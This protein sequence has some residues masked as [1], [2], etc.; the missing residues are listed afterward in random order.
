M[1]ERTPPTERPTRGTV[2]ALDLGSAGVLETA[3]GLGTAGAVA[4]VLYQLLTGQME[5]MG[6]D[7][8]EMGGR[9]E[10]IQADVTALRTDVTRLQVEAE[11]D[12]ATPR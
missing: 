10:R 12:R 7:I 2:G 3:R 5:R 1:T 11:R 8:D 9:I 4:A 6:D